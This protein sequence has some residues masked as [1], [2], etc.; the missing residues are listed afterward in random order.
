MRTSAPFLFNAGT[1]T[2]PNRFVTLNKATDTVSH[3][4]TDASVVGVTV[5]EADN[6]CIAVYSVKTVERELKI[7]LNATVAV[8]AALGS[9]AN[10]LAISATAGAVA[11]A[12]KAGIAGDL[13]PIY[14]I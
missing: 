5:G 1:V 8:G 11:Y 13:I 3:T 12:K 10:G 9:D 2:E 7:K 4:A 14:N 6:D